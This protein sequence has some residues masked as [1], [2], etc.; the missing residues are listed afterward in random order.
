MQRNFLKPLDIV[1]LLW[2]NI[3]QKGGDDM[4][5]KTNAN[6]SASIEKALQILN[7]AVKNSDTLKRVNVTITLE[8]PRN[9]K[10]S[11]KKTKSK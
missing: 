11:S 5:D 4:C 3:R 6:S 2:Y 10:T 7:E 8:K 9:N 1:V